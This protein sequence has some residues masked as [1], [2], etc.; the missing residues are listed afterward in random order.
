MVC[1][2]FELPLVCTHSNQLR[3]STYANSICCEIVVLHVYEPPDCIARVMAGKKCAVHASQLLH[4]YAITI[5]HLA[6]VVAP[7][8]FGNRL[9]V[10]CSLI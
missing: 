9:E 10:A 5:Q 2:L 8:T 6:V 4:A 1:S 7:H 3:D